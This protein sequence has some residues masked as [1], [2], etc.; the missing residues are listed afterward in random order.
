MLMTLCT[1]GR[2]GDYAHLTDGMTL[3]AY[4]R[5]GDFARLSE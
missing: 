4:E 3:D 1:Y 2:K 5:K